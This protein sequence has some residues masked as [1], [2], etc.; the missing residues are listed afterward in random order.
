M[1]VIIFLIAAAGLMYSN[2][3]FANHKNT[4]KKTI[5]FHAGAGPRGTA[6]QIIDHNDV[7]DRAMSIHS[8][9]PEMSAHAP[10]RGFQNAH[11]PGLLQ[12]NAMS[13]GQSS[14][15]SG[16]WEASY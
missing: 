3:W 14:G 12:H 10:G 7:R 8:Q 6:R 1:I 15:N 9:R 4:Q 11:R 13:A 2:G 16:V 5:A